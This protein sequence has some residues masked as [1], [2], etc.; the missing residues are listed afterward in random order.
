MMFYKVGLPQSRVGLLLGID[1]TAGVFLWEGIH[2]GI[3]S[4]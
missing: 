3:C 1:A 2:H 4:S